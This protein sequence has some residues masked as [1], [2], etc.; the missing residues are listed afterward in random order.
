[1]LVSI[2]Q[3]RRGV[4]SLEVVG[5]AKSRA[6]YRK[7]MRQPAGMGQRK[8]NQYQNPGAETDMGK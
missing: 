1:L 4:L 3:S 5:D 6:S 2:S 7:P 8:S